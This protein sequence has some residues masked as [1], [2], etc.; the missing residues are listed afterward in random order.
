MPMKIYFSGLVLVIALVSLILLILLVRERRRRAQRDNAPQSFPARLKRALTNTLRLVGFTL[1]TILLLAGGLLAYVDY[2]TMLSDLA[3]TPSQVEIPP[4]LPFQVEEVRF[5]GGDNL[6]LAGWYTPP[7]NDV[8]IILLHGSGGNRLGMLWHAK[9]LVKAGY[10]VLMYDER[11]SGESEGQRR[12]FGWEDAPDVGGA[13][14]FLNSRTA[15]GNAQVGIAGCSI[16]G[17]IALQGAARYPQIAATWADGP[18]V[19]RGKD[20]PIYSWP[21][22]LS[23]VSTHLIDQMYISRG[24]N[25]PPAMIDLIG[26]IEPRPVT[27]VAGGNPHPIFGPEYLHVEYFARY[28]GE[29]TSLWVIPEATHCDGPSQRPQEYAR[30]MLEFFDQTFKIAR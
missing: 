30:R 7:A 2:Q 20:T 29:H 16:G 24:I 26:R 27:L 23:F 12:S 10:G 28:A 11:A 15:G 25:A 8:T 22:L 5:T 21:T 17:Q 3:P 1:L 6:K 13:L 14:D 19:I 4:D 9:V 18:A